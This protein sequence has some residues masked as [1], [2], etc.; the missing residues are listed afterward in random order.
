M[1]TI[2]S[3]AGRRLAKAKAEVDRIESIVRGGTHLAECEQA[4][5]EYEAA[6]DAVADEL[7][8]QGFHEID[9]ED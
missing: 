9:G 1:M 7:I 6:A 2:S 5:K 8:H 4:V 3:P